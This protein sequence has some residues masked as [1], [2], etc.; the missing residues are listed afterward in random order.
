MATLLSWGGNKVGFERFG[1]VSFTAQTK[2]DKFVDLLDEGKVAGTKCKSCGKM[3]FP[4]RADC[5]NCL[6]SDMEWFEISGPGKLI[7]FSTLMYAPTGFE[8][9]L[10]Y[11]IALADFGDVKVFGR[12]SKDLE[13]ADMEIGMDVQVVPVKLQGEKVSYEF[14]KA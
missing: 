2:V 14:K 6:S 7:S 12:M 9:D 1:T 13:E 5:S 4:P 10:P 11:A 3:Y 8:D